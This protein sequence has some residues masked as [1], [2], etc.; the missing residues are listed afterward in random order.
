MVKRKIR[1]NIY[2]NTGEQEFLR[3]RWT[4]AIINNPNEIKK[5]QQ[6]LFTQLNPCADLYENYSCGI[7]NSNGLH[8]KV[9]SFSSEKGKFSLKEV[10]NSNDFK[11]DRN[12]KDTSEQNLENYVQNLI[13]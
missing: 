3:N 13:R 4:F 5:I 9:F 2:T 10:Y 12:L 6:K 8:C 11:K 1:Y 7:K